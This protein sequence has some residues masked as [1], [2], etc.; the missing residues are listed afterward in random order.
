[1]RLVSSAV[2]LPVLFL[3]P[4]RAQPDASTVKTYD[5]LTNLE[6]VRDVLP[7]LK[8]PFPSLRLPSDADYGRLYAAY[9]SAGAAVRA[10]RDPGPERERAWL[11]GRKASLL[12]DCLVFAEFVNMILAGK[13]LARVE[14]DGRGLERLTEVARCGVFTNARVVRGTWKTSRREYD[15]AWRL[16]ELKFLADG[17]YHIQAGSRPQGQADLGPGLDAIKKVGGQWCVVAPDGRVKFRGL[18]TGDIIRHAELQ[19]QGPDG[20]IVLKLQHTQIFLGGT[21][22]PYVYGNTE[23]AAYPYRQVW[24]STRKNLV[25]FLIHRPRFPPFETASR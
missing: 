11:S 25:V 21:T 13:P 14:R 7:K 20:A 2:L 6:I 15:V 4:A 24:G 19:S 23:D 22:R 18:R 5:N 8:S 12:K 10:L 1:M 16:P 17:T 3:S 9:A